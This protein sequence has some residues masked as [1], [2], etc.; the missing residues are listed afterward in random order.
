V[1][2]VLKVSRQFSAFNLSVAKGKR[3]NPVLSAEELECFCLGS[4]FL[5]S[6]FDNFRKLFLTPTRKIIMNKS[7]VLAAII[8]AAALSACG[9]KEEAA[10]PAAPV[11]APAAAPASDASAAPAAAPASDASAAK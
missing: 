1:T 3:Y 11:A 8:A 10:A 5:E 2:G 6:V 4:S 7:L 9:K